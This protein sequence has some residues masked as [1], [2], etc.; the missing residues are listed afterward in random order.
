[1]F[2]RHVLNMA[3]GVKFDEIYERSDT[4]IARLSRPWIRGAFITR[5]QE[6]HE[7]HRPSG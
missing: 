2:I 6:L 3:A 1:M 7:I 5:R 4:D